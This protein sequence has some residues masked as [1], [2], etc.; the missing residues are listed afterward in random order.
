MIY[1]IL[2]FLEAFEC[3]KV[4]K[5]GVLLISTFPTY[6]GFAKPE[7]QNRVDELKI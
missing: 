3:F 7:F 5:I 1:K 4:Y 2:L 6:R